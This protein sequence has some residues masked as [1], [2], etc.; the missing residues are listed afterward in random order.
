MQ[1]GQKTSW[2]HCSRG[3]QEGPEV[4]QAIKLEDLQ[5]PYSKS[6]F[7]ARFPFLKVPPSSQIAPPEGDQ[8][9]NHMNIQETLH[10]QTTALPKCA[11]H[12][13]QRIK[14]CGHN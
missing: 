12:G 2:L 1:Q 3:S 14:K 13:R 8:V 4:G 7:P 5:V 9:F 10:I 6:L 11:S